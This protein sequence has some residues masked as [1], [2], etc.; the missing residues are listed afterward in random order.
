VITE[1]QRQ[2]VF[3]WLERLATSAFSDDSQENAKA[4]LAMFQE[5]EEVEMVVLG[6]TT[7]HRP[8]DEIRKYILTRDFEES[9]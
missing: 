6:M 8:H 7:A 5:A 9:E 3:D 2:D 1:D 4:A